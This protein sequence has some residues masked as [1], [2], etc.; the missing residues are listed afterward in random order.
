MQG[1][2][3]YSSKINER[4]FVSKYD[5]SNFNSMWIQGDYCDMQ[6]DY[7]IIR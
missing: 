3:I 2:H 5:E 7:C 1:T 6:D 4:D